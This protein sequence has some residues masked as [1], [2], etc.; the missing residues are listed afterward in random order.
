MAHLGIR[1]GELDGKPYARHWNPTMAPLAEPIRAALALGPQA[2]ELGFPVDEADRLLAPGDLDLETGWT[3]LADG[4]I[5]VAVRTP[6][7]N[8]TAA[9]IDWWFGWHGDEAQR[10]KLWHPRAHVDV[11]MEKPLA[12]VGG[13]ADRERY[14]GNPSTVTEY[15]GARRYDL[16]IAF[17]D[18]GDYFDRRKLA[19]APVGTAVCARTGFVSPGIDAGHLIHLIRT[20]ADG[21]EMRSRFWVGESAWSSLGADHPFNCYVLGRSSRSAQAF[22]PDL[23]RDLLVHC[24]AEMA[25]LASFLPALYGDYHP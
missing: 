23:G 25:H 16:V 2:P 13:L 20:T 19:A 24:A 22:V 18:A 7:P 11:R 15:L 8:V 1:P 17:R 9:M 3:R 10:Y 12:D 4:Q 6:M 5:F 14:V 21:C